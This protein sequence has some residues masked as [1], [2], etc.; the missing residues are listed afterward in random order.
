MNQF[1]ARVTEHLAALPAQLTRL[2]AQEFREHT[3]TQ[4]E[5]LLPEEIVST[6]HDQAL[7][8][9]DAS[10]TRRDL[11]V[12]A[13]GN[14][15]R[16]YRSVGRD[17]IHK[18]DGPITQFFK[19]DAIRSYLS[20]IA[21]EPLHKVPYAP[22]E[23]I[24]NSQ[25]RSGDTHGWHWDDYTFALIWVVEAPDC[26]SGGRVEFVP[27][28]EWDKERPRERLEQIVANQEI[29]SRY[30]RSG[31]CYLMRANTT[32]HRVAPLFGDTRR[33]VIVFTFASTADMT[34]S[35]ISHETMEQI[36]APE[37]DKAAA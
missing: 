33:T 35:S 32:L 1:E 17:T 31:T 4:M 8:L 20:E 15:P 22:E 7:R 16:A 36:Y 10:A 29:R 14:T 25:E 3:I 18:D 24:I 27:D 5:H 19:S 9:V 13:T 30:V 37:L 12:A 11:D 21:G 23:Y 26:M 2:L 28:T 34:D 6:L